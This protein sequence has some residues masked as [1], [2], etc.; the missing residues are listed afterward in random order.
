MVRH[1]DASEL[2]QFSEILM[3]QTSLL[4]APPHHVDEDFHL[5]AADDAHDV[6]HA[7]LRDHQGNP[8]AELV[9]RLDRLLQQ[10]FD[11]ATTNTVNVRSRVGG[12]L[13]KI[14]FEEGQMVKA[15]DLLAEIDPRSYQNALLQAQGTLMQ[16]QAQL[17]NAQVDVERY[18]GL[19]REDS[20]A[21]QTLDTQEALVNQYRGTVK[22]RTLM[23]ALQG[24]VGQRIIDSADLGHRFLGVGWCVGG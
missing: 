16:S 4:L 6:L 9:L 1:F 2:A 10:A 5:F 3:T 11:T 18:R 14:N 15:G 22:R 20:I 21:K 7:V 12:E 24:A 19:Y 23:F 13:V 17:K 8:V